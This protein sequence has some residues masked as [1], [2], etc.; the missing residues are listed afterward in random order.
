[1]LF[2]GATQPSRCVAPNDLCVGMEVWRC[3]TSETVHLD[4]I[5]AVRTE[6]FFK[7]WL[8]EKQKHAQKVIKMLSLN[9]QFGVLPSLNAAMITFFTT[10]S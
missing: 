6:M 5:A 4:E 2:T 7:C 9:T 8:T 1:M 3:A 10:K